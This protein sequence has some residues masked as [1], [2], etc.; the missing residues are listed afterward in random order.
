MPD[1]ALPT[2]AAQAPP[3][4]VAARDVL[5]A[6]REAE[7]VEREAQLA[8]RTAK[9]ES[10]QAAHARLW[11]QYAQLKLELDLVKRRLFVASAS[12]EKH[13]CAP[14]KL[15]IFFG[16]PGKCFRSGQVQKRRGRPNDSGRPLR[17]SGA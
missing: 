6:Q 2:P 13:L 10:L 4:E 8:E 15:L 12:G 1:S 3:P 17:F 9:L 16:V 7:V 5:L 11:E 14:L